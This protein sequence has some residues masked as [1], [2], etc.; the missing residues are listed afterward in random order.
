MDATLMTAVGSFITAVIGIVIAAATAR[1]AATRDEV[2]SLR[3]TLKALQEE[4]ERLRKRVIE[5]EDEAAKRDQLIDANM[6]ELI[7]LRKELATL[8]EEN[9][10]LKMKPRGEV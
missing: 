10:R 9:H 3:R 2:E 5:L 4:N 1:S 6:V 7:Q 8:R